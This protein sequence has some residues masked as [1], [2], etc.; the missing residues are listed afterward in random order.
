MPSEAEFRVTCYRTRNKP[1]A[2]S[3][4]HTEVMIDVEEPAELRQ[5][6]PTAVMQKLQI[7]QH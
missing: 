1:L 2:G 6:V 7:W 5:E 4:S 3:A